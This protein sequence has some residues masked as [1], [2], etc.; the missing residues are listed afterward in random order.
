MT[1]QG[2]NLTMAFWKKTNKPQGKVHKN[3]MLENGNKNS[4][5]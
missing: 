5:A 4:E 2:F 3:R 1:T